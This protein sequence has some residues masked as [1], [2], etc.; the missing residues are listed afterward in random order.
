MLSDIGEFPFD[1]SIE[2]NIEKVIGK[3][4]YANLERQAMEIG[5]GLK[6]N[7]QKLYKLLEKEPESR[8]LEVLKYQLNRYEHILRDDSV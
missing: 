3:P 5:F 1:K 7:Y 8:A 4:F 2:E 6:I